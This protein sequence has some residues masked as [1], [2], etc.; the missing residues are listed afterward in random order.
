MMNIIKSKHFLV[1]ENLKIFSKIIIKRIFLVHLIVI[2]TF[3]LH[4]NLFFKY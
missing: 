1:L 2:L 4:K 3:L